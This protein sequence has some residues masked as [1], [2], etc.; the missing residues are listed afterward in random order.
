MQEGRRRDLG[1]QVVGCL[2]RKAQVRHVEGGGD[3]V[4]A[5]VG[6]AEGRQHERGD[7]DRHEETERRGRQ[8]APRPSCVEPSERNAPGSL[9]L[10]DQQARDQEAG[11]DEEDVDTDV[12]AGDPGHTG[13]EQ[14][15]E[16]DGDA[17]QSLEVGA[18]AGPTERARALTRA[19]QRAEF[20]S[21]ERVWRL[22]SA[23]ALWARSRPSALVGRLAWQALSSA[24]AERP[25]WLDPSAATGFAAVGLAEAFG[26]AWAAGLAATAFGFA[27]AAGLAA[28][29]LGFP[30]RDRFGWSFGAAW[31]RGSGFRRNRFR[32]R[33]FRG[34]R[35]RAAG[36]AAALGL[37][38]AVFETARGFEAPADAALGCAFTVSSLGPSLGSACSALG[39]RG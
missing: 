6:N 21:V 36:F 14:Q 30:L 8:E 10:T 29:V 19:A 7:R 20:V 38:V 9:D 11:Q 17:A 37:G 25:V 27:W 31:L 39:R 24:S 13:V 32:G 1:P 23:R 5:D 2:E 18:E 4:G 16:Q 28:A 34:G 22:P 12:P 15:H 33:G 26:F 35:F 3:T